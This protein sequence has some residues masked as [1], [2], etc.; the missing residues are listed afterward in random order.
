MA[1]GSV[2]T[3]NGKNAILKRM[4]GDSSVS[5]FSKFAIGTGTTTPSETDTDLEAKITGWYGGADYK[6]YMTGYPTYDATNNSVTIRCKVL[7]TEANGNTITE[8]GE[9]NTD[10]TPIILGR[11]VFTGISKSSSVE[12]IFEIEHQIN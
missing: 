7:S 8:I 6:G 4:Y 10:G 1:N 9:F 12:I 2:I 5:A 11:D 3:S